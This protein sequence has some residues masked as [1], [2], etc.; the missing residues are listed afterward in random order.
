MLN[1]AFHGRSPAIYL[2]EFS[3]LAVCLST[4]DIDSGQAGNANASMIHPSIYDTR[5]DLD[6]DKIS[7]RSYV[8]PY[9]SRCSL[10]KKENLWSYSQ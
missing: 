9:P 3:C 4:N 2:G 6:I 7:R 8:P 5:H 1:V 10:S